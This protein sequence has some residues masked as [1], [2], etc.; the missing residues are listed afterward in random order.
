[1]REALTMTELLQDLDWEPACQIPGCFSSHP[2][3]SHT[4]TLM[5]CDCLHLACSHCAAIL[6]GR[7][8]KLLAEDGP[9]YCHGCHEMVAMLRVEPLP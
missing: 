1:M 5:P 2:P 9:R 4:V 3:A 7:A 6:A 8:N